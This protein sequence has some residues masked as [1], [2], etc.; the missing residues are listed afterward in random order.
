MDNRVS[1]LEWCST[2]DNLNHSHVIEKASVAKFRKVK[3]VT[4]GKIFNSANEGGRYYELNNPSS[5]SYA[6]NGKRKSVKTKNNVRLQWKYIKNLTE[7]ERVK[8]DIENKLNKLN[9]GCDN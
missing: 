3:C 6:C 2:L 1:N 5:V 9:K 8:Y 7:E 4:T